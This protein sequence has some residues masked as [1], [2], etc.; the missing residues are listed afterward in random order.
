MPIATRIEANVCRNL[1]GVM[2]SGQGLQAALFGEPV[3][4]VH[5]RLDDVL[6][7]VV[8]R[9]CRVGRGQEHRIVWRGLRAYG[10]VLGQDLPQQREQLDREARERIIGRARRLDQLL[11]SPA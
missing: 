5:H 6:A 2:P 3:R 8:P 1:C 4:P 7:Q 9:A 11:P 10:L